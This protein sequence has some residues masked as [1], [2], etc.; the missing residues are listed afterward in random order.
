MQMVEFTCRCPPVVIIFH[1]DAVKSEKVDFLF[2]ELYFH[3][4]SE[5]SQQF[6]VLFTTNLISYVQIGAVNKSQIV[7][8]I[9]TSLTRV[10]HSFLYVL[11]NV[12][13]F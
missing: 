9:D 10:S 2:Q 6:S 11:Q 13:F 3:L 7:T 5:P 12:I 8:D 4:C 1:K